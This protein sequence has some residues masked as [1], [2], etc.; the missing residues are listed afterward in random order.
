[1]ATSFSKEYLAVIEAAR[2]RGKVTE[3]TERETRRHPRLKLEQGVVEVPVTVQLTVEDVGLGGIALWSDLDFPAGARLRVSM[4]SLF[5]TDVE[6]VGSEMVERPGLFLE[7]KYLLHCRFTDDHAAEEFLV[8]M[9]QMES[10][11]ISANR[12]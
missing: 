9:A 10:L 4:R 8:M 1:M 3:P 2:A 7:V 12:T 11:D 6:V 5:A